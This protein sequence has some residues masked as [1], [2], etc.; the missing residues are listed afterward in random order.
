MNT[1][2]S[3]LLPAYRN[4]GESLIRELAKLM[5]VPGMVSLAG[6]YPGPELFDRDG[7]REAADNA[8]ASAPVAC[9][10][11]GPTDGL[12]A[13]REGIAGW[14]DEAGSRC[15]VDDIL[16]TAGSQQGFDLLV[17]T[18]LRPGDVA[19]VE[20]P[21][22]TGPL[23][24]LKIAEVSTRTV[25]VDHN[26]LDVDELEAVLVE[27]AK[28]QS[29]R[30]KL[31][32]VVPTFANPS[33][34]TMPLAR[35]LRLLELAVKYGVVVVEDDPYGR[36]RFHG[37]PQPHLLSLVDQVPGARD[38]VVHLG[39][40]S[41]V[42]APGLRT[43]WLIAAPAI[44]RAC[45]IA[46]Q[47]DDL[48]N[49]GFTQMTVARYLEAGRLRAHLPVILGAYRE[50]AQAMR[51]AIAT[52][53]SSRVAVNVP[54]GGMFMWGRIRN[55][56]S[57]RDLLKH[58]IDEKVT[59]VAGDIYYADQTDPATLRLSFSTPTPDQIRTGIARI[60]QALDRLGPA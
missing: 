25:G 19:L 7:L 54:E 16:V 41:K 26:G 60:S 5:S 52:H 59:F 18:L 2:E 49:P 11:Y 33:G 1:P 53:L 6:G 9:L 44:R 56:A 50:R 31:L 47:L 57:A 58:A 24:L 30:P 15:S 32:Y 42:I 36:L 37:D 17:R 28:G 4:I 39:S 21:T 29:P 23:R 8:L 12:P 3:Y 48:S 51:E 22:Y 46:K 27:A 10:Q 14:M 38:W 35:R 55:G 40:F 43:G 45:L 13:L 34:A 20:R